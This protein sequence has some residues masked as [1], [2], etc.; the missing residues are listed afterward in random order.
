MQICGLFIAIVLITAGCFQ[1][2]SPIDNIRAEVRQSAAQLAVMEVV[3]IAI[4]HNIKTN[5]LVSDDIYIRTDRARRYYGYSID[6]VIKHLSIEEKEGKKYL[7]VILPPPS[8][9]PGT[10]DRK[11]IGKPLVTDEDYDPAKAEGVDVDE[12]ISNEIN[13]QDRLIAPLALEKA[14]EMTRLYFETL[15]RKFDMEAVIDYR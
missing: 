8:R 15:A 3:Y 12:R 1:E 10:E 14:R 6:E 9:L 11:M 5:W 2:K 13:E 4:Y 7:R